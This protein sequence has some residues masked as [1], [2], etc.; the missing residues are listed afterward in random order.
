VLW[1]TFAPAVAGQPRMRLSGDRGRSYRSERPL[2]SARPAQPAAVRLFDD[3]GRASCLALDLD[4]GRGGRRQVVA[5]CGRLEALAVTVGA[6]LVVDESTSG[7]RH[8]YLP[9]ATRRSV[10]ELRPVVVGLRALCPSVDITPM[11]NP[12]AGCIR[13]PGAAHKMGGWQRLLTPF[14]GAV[15]SFQRRNDDR[16]WQRLT[17]RV[18]AAI[19]PVRD[20]AGEELGGTE[21]DPPRAG[22]PLPPVYEAI[23]LTGKFDRAVYP[24]RSEAR[25]AVVS[26]AAARGWTLTEVAARVED[27]RWRGLAAFYARYRPGWRRTA[28]LKDWRTALTEIAAWRAARAPVPNSPTRESSSHRGQESSGG[29][30][31]EGDFR[32]GRGGVLEY[33]F[34]RRWWLATERAAPDRYTTRAGLTLRAVL[35]AL[36]AAGQKVGSRYVAFGT[37]SLSLSAGRDHTTVAEALRVLRDEPDPFVVLLEGDRGADGDL[38][39]LRIPDRYLALVEQLRWPGGKIPGVDPVFRVLGLPAH[40]VYQALSDTDPHTV[41]DLARAAVISRSAAYRAL[42]TLADAGLARRVAGGWRRG[43][44][45]LARARVLCGAAELVT[46]L[47]DRFAVE[48]QAWWAVLGEVRH[49]PPPP[50]AQVAPA[51][52]ATLS[53]LPPPAEPDLEPYTV[54]DLLYEVLGAVPIEEQITA[55]LDAV[56]AGRRD[57]IETVLGEHD[58]LAFD[59]VADHPGSA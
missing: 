24:S 6:R 18:A 31:A 2:T 58:Q 14:A 10:D 17:A 5:D 38:Y 29:P 49:L 41:V 50:P 1:E 35:H 43:R 36:G 25:Q 26:S 30:T 57:P 55:V 22:G 16:V 3:D 15:T 52:V 33:R 51:E 53:G 42:D 12:A 21:L 7:G 23:A 32:S 44:M 28:L 13:P 37:R 9:L 48:R 11:V 8:V 46:R 54:G 47:R 59:E 19:G 20:G 4:V 39:E 56:G 27:G 34:L 40:F 45:A